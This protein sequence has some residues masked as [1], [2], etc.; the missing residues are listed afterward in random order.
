MRVPQGF[1]RGL[2]HDSDLRLSSHFL[3]TNGVSL[4][5]SGLQS[6]VYQLYWSIAGINEL[7]PL[8][9]DTV[10]GQPPQVV[11]FPVGHSA[12]L[13]TV[14]KVGTDKFTLSV[15]GAFVAPSSIWIVPSSTPYQWKL[16]NRYTAPAPGGE[17]ENFVVWT[18]DG[19]YGW[20]Y[21]V[22]G[23]RRDIIPRR[24]PGELLLVLDSGSAG[25]WWFKRVA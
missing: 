12:P 14:T 4:R 18:N 3:D 25:P 16:Q 15:G 22:L 24:P 13:W 9:I 11:M 6:G 8:G 2:H 1:D 23:G 19:S 17:T 20:D 21:L 7:Q 10:D 5:M